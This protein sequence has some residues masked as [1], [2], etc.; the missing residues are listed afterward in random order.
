MGMLFHPGWNT[1]V[2][3]K[4]PLKLKKD[5][6][7]KKLLISLL[8][9]AALSS[10]ANAATVTFYDVT[11]NV[12]PA[13][14]NFSIW[15]GAYNA[16]GYCYMKGFDDALTYTTSCGEDE[17]SFAEYKGGNKWSTRSSGS[18]NQCYP[19]LDSVTCSIDS[20]DMRGDKNELQNQ[21]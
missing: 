10:A 6:M 7:M 16:Y 9:V 5:K 14:N 1:T 8:S 11:Q 3:C 4:L 19:I 13:S 12:P 20:F 18:K 2:Q 17:M 15:A 21:Q